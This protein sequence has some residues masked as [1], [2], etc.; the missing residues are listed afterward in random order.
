MFTGVPDYSAHITITV[1]SSDSFN[2]FS[3]VYVIAEMWTDS[4]APS[5]METIVLTSK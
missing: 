4:I 3:H 1:Q 2:S 5:Q